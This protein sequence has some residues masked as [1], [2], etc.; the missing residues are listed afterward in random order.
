MTHCSF[1][2]HSIF[3]A[4]AI[5]AAGIQ[6]ANPGLDP[7]AR[8]VL[9]YLASVHGRK[10]LA[11]YNVYPHTPD[12]YTQ[13]GRMAAVWGRDIRWLGD[14]DE[15]I[16]HQRHHRYL[17]TL[18]WHWFFDDDSAWQGKRSSPVDVGRLVTPGTPEHRQAMA[19][20]DAAADT[21]QRLED[22]GIPV[23]W[24]PLHEIDG[25]WFW[26]TDKQNPGN[27]AKLWRMMFEHFTHKRNLDNL[28]WVYSAGV[29][30]KTVEER[31]AYYPGADFVDISGIDIYGVDI[32]VADPKYRAYHET[33]TRVSPGKML[34]CCEADALPDPDMMQRGELPGWLWVMPWWGTPDPRRPAGRAT[35]TMRHDHVVTLDELPAFGSGNIPPHLGID[36]PL[37]DGSAWFA[38]PDDAPVIRAFASDRDGRVEQVEFFAGNTP[39]GRDDTAP[40]ELTWRDAP[41]GCHEVTAVAVDDRGAS[42]SSNPV[43]IATGMVDLARGRPVNASPGEAPG[44]AVD[45]DYYTCWSA[46]KGGDAWL[47][48]DL[49]GVHAIDRVNLHWG[50]KIHPAEFTIE[51][52]TRAPDAESSW[53]RVAVVSERPYQTWRAVDRVRF[54]A[55]PAR[56][57]RV[58]CSRRAGN[59]TWAGYRLAAIEVPVAAAGPR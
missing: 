31:S 49:G 10:V 20:L 37:D 28:I 25:G 36:Q 40:Y 2:I 19:E 26:W 30:N 27:T 35:R 29:G 55:T 24:R 14:C 48:V 53:T 9:D 1:P 41:V 33:M 42:S 16:A 50:W 45:G 7:P 5:P 12:D 38:S 59:Q 46:A 3:L 58:R 43:R 4:L 18:H 54:T 17:L 11:G 39:I 47:A 15:V 6:P 22:A 57:V 8:K 13:T 44:Q 32:Q 52:A 34:A 56:H 23:L 21:L 51:V